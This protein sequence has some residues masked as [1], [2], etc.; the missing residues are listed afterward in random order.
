MKIISSIINAYAQA[1]RYLNGED[2]DLIAY[3]PTKL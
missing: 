1:I 3:D 2:L